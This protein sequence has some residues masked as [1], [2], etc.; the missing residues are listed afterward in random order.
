MSSSSSRQMARAWSNW[1]S[2]YRRWPRFRSSR[3]VEHARARS[4]RRTTRRMTKR[5]LSLDFSRLGRKDRDRQEQRL[6]TRKTGWAGAW[7]VF[8]LRRAQGAWKQVALP[9]ALASD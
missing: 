1:F 7:L 3:Y 2:S 8:G 5:D 4:A 9:G 6:A